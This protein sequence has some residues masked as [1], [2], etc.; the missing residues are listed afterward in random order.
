MLEDQ[1][2][3]KMPPIDLHSRYGPNSSAIKNEKFQLMRQLRRVERQEAVADL[4]KEGRK[5]AELMSNAAAKYGSDL[6]TLKASMN[7]LKLKMAAVENQRQKDM[8]AYE[9]RL[10]VIAKRVQELETQ[11]VASPEIPVK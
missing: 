4:Q 8:L 9:N 7:D 5:I 10:R 6:E 2:G 11:E 1:H 3:G